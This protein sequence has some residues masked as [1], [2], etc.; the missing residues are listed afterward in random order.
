[1]S[2]SFKY[3]A[4]LRHVREVALFGTA[5]LAFWR[6]RLRPAG[7]HPTEGEGGA[8]RMIGAI[9]SR[10]LGVPFREATI[11]VILTRHPGGSGQDG[12]YLARAF[13]SSRSFAFV[14][15]ACFSS[16]YLH[17]SLRI[18]ARHPASFEVSRGGEAALIARMSAAP[19][20]LPSRSED[21]SWQGPVFLP[22]QPGKLFSA[23]I[24]GASCTYPFIAAEDL[25]TIRP[26]REDTALR[27]LVESGFTGREW[28][29]R[30][31]A[32]HAKGKTVAR[33]PAAFG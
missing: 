4:E 7:L 27:S 15:R 1:M 25:V 3:V 19:G 20:R 5:D 32:S 14:E 24:A 11:S 17:G 31:D 6:D 29:I 21:Q 26:L 12:V 8:Q 28:V 30:A 10:F 2:E 33:S 18:D 22:G 23:R 9:E 13:N 16:P